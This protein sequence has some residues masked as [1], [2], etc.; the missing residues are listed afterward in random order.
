MISCDRFRCHLWNCAN[1]AIH[2]SL[3][4]SGII[5]PPASFTHSWYTL[6]SAMIKYSPTFGYGIFHEMNY[7]VNPPQVS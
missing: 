7:N 3:M 4:N 1:L 6:L 2:A 5:T